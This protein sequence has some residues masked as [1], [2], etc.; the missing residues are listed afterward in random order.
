MLTRDVESFEVFPTVTNCAQ[1]DIRHRPGLATLACG[2]AACHLLQRTGGGNLAI[3]K[4]YGRDRLRLLRCRSCGEKFF[5]PRGTAWFNTTIA[6]AKAASII[7]HLDVGSGLDHGMGHL[8]TLR[9][10]KNERLPPIKVETKGRP[11]HP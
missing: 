7:D 9:P 5:A 6:E 8:A 3:R 11:H 10:E 4:V 2:N 1:E